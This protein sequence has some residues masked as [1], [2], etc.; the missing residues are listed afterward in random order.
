M[1]GSVLKHA[2]MRLFFILFPYTS[3]IVLSFSVQSCLG[4]FYRTSRDSKDI[5]SNLRSTY[6]AKFGFSKF[7]KFG[8]EP[9]LK[10]AG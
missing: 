1:T 6:T 8:F 2:A 5:G 10:I 9:T 3:L 4:I 7:R